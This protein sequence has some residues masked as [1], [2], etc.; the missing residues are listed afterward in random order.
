LAEVAGAFGPIVHVDLPRHPDG[1]HTGTAIVEY[2]NPEACSTAAMGLNGLAIGDWRLTAGKVRG[3]SSAADM[4][5]AA[6]A[7][8]GGGGGGYGGGDPGHGGSYP[9]GSIPLPPPTHMHGGG[10]V[11][12]PPLPPPPPPTGPLGPAGEQ[13]AVGGGGGR[14]AEGAGQRCLL[15]CGAGA[16]QPSALSGSGD[17]TGPHHTTPGTAARSS[18]CT[19]RRPAPQHAPVHAPGVT[20]HRSTPPPPTA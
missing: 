20:Q 3:P 18:A 16:A 9:P 8:G 11:S 12:A 15:C 17:G 7:G 19:G 10:G 5:A 1:S 4:A 13:H 14:G 6:Y 2:A